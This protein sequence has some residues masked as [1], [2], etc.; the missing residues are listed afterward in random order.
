M[1]HQRPEPAIPG[2][3]AWVMDADEFEKHAELSDWCSLKSEYVLWNA[4]PGEEGSGMG[5]HP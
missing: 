4:Y 1:S 2:D 3:T 5:Q